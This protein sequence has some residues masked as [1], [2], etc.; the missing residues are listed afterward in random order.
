M[1]DISK[2]WV[3]GTEYD[4]KDA[5]ARQELTQK[6]DESDVETISG[7]IASLMGAVG[8]PLVASTVA[9]MTDH[10]KIY[11]Y[12]GSETGYTAGNWYY[13]DSSLA[14]PA[15][16]SGGVYNSTAFT[17]DTT[18]SVSGAAADAAASRNQGMFVLSEYGELG[19]SSISTS[20]VNLND[21]NT[22]AVYAITSYGASSHPTNAPKADAGVCLFVHLP[23]FSATSIKIQ[24]WINYSTKEAYIRYK[25]AGGSAS[26]QGWKKIGLDASLLTTLETQ[27]KAYTDDEIIENNIRT[28]TPAYSQTVKYHVG[29]TVSYGDSVY[30][31]LKMADNEA[32]D[33]EKW[34]Q[35]DVAGLLEKDRFRRAAITRDEEKSF[36]NGRSDGTLFSILDYNVAHLNNN[37]SVGIYNLPTKEKY[38]NFKRM[39]YEFPAD[40]VTVQENATTVDNTGN[41]SPGTKSTLSYLFAPLYPAKVDS[42]PSIYG[43]TAGTFKN[44]TL[45][46]FPVEDS[47]ETIGVTVRRVKL[48]KNGIDLYV[49]TFLL[50]A[51][52]NWKK[53]K[54]QLSGLISSCLSQDNY[55]ANF[56][57]IGDFNTGTLT[58]ND[59]DAEVAFLHSLETQ[60]NATL[61]NG[62]YLGWIRTHATTEFGAIDNALVSNTCVITKFKPLGEWYPLLYSDHYPVLLDVTVV[63]Q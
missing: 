14:T 42:G 11:V 2:L 48:S 38:Y 17:T 29:D 41:D 45:S 39:L 58:P 50:I 5:V 62:G 16:T 1:P 25:T 20:A 49:Y 47:E 21:F 13:W 22:Q 57:F 4:I 52:S 51:A 8:S 61:A 63:N 27:L 43:K 44:F 6:A 36:L 28:I 59:Y 3:E 37:T 10:T 34:A 7:Q 53:R 32:F 60:Y 24:L 31:C 46:G 40:C 54:A 30:R 12:T 23:A 33:S 55:P 19:I 18:I 15:W 56:V 35:V 26:W 9:A